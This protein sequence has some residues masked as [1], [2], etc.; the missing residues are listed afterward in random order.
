MTP[1]SNPTLLES[2]DGESRAEFARVGDVFPL[3]P[4]ASVLA[5]STEAPS[6]PDTRPWGLR[7][8]VSPP[9]RREVTEAADRWVY[10]PVRQQ[11]IDRVTGEPSAGKRSS[12]TKETTG[13]PDGN[14]PTPE[15][16]TTD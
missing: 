5:A 10:D 8:A 3:D 6:G 14:G 1:Q 11:G 13:E 9:V 7:F 2:P 15:E 12:G 16:T 4:S